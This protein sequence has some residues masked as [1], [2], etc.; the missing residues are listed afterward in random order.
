MPSKN[1]S[2]DQITSTDELLRCWNEFLLNKF[3]APASNLD[4]GIEQVVSEEEYLSDKELDNVLNNDRQA[5][6]Q[7][8]TI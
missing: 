7:A 6:H 8:G 3:A 4:K 1:H 5:K 2:G